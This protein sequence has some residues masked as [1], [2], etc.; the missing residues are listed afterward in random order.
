VLPIERLVDVS[1][2]RARQLFGPSKLVEPTAGALSM[3]PIGHS[4]GIAASMLG[5]LQLQRPC[6]RVSFKI[7][8]TRADEIV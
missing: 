6:G 4:I 5:M 7:K 8:K 3:H 2:R 1:M